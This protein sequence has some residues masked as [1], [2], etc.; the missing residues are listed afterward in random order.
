MLLLI[1]FTVFNAHGR[2][3]HAMHYGVATLS[4]LQ[5]VPLWHRHIARSRVRHHRII[6]Q[7]VSATLYMPD[8]QDA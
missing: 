8:V 1:G 4:L 6:F 7:Y 3:V 2:I 5:P